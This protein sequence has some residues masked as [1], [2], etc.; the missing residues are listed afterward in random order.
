MVDDFSRS[1]AQAWERRGKVSI[2][3]DTYCMQDK[4]PVITRGRSPLLADAEGVEYLVEQV[5]S[6]GFS[7]YSGKV[8]HG[9]IK[10]SGDKFF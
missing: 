6:Y 4:D 8:V 3:S 9:D 2:T 1:H 7:Q 10:I 5:I